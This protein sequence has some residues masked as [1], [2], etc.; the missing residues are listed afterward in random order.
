M[1]LPTCLLL[2]YGVSTAA[3]AFGWSQSVKA[4]QVF[5]IELPN[6]A[7][8]GTGAGDRHRPAATW[9]GS[10]SRRHRMKQ[11]HRRPRRPARPQRASRSRPGIAL[12]VGALTVYWQATGGHRYIEGVQ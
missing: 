9:S 4:G 3:V 1:G 8:L 10:S 6:A 5:G 11:Q 2:E 7:L 12:L